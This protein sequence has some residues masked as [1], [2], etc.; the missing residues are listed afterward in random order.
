VPYKFRASGKVEKPFDIVI[1]RFQNPAR[2]MSLRTPA[3]RPIG[4]VRIE[5]LNPNERPFGNASTEEDP[6]QAV[7]GIG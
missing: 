6:K 1:D 3:G 4:F 5:A 2:P 7:D